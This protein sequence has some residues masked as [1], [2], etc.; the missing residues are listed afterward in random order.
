MVLW[1]GI[2]ARLLQL[3]VRKF[4]KLVVFLYLIASFVWSSMEL[5]LIMLG[6]G[7]FCNGQTIHASQTDRVSDHVLIKILD[8]SHITRLSNMTRLIQK[9]LVLQ[10]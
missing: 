1:L 10:L 8:F 2:H 9:A 5:P 3:L 4:T 6:G 7:A